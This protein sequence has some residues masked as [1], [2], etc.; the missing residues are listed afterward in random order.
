ML[1][2]NGRRQKRDRPPPTSPK[3]GGFQFFSGLAKL[4]KGRKE[5]EKPVEKTKTIKTHCP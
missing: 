5:W 4:E 3:G 1:R 2:A